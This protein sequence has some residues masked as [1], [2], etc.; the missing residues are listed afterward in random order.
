MSSIQTMD[1]HASHRP[2]TA[3]VDQKLEVVIIPVSDV[4]RAK[5]FYEGLGWRLDADFANGDDW[6]LVQMTPPGSPCSVMFGRGVTS[7]VP[8][9]LQGAFLVVDDLETARNELGRRGVEVSEVFHFQA[10]LLNARAVGY[11]RA[12]PKGPLVFLVRLVQ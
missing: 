11:A 1:G 12:R 7:A 9:S 5:T 3:P 4:D 10:D 6:R 2:D 8:G